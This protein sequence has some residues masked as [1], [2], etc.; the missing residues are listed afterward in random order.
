MSFLHNAELVIAIG[1]LIFVGILIYY[2]VPNLIGQKLD[3]R[4]LRI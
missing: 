4:A 3:E 2:R 1:F